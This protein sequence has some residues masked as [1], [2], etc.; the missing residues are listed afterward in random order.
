MTEQTLIERLQLGRAAPGNS[1]YLMQEAAAKLLESYEAQA[2]QAV[3]L[4]SW[5]R[6][7][8]R[9]KSEIESERANTK[10]VGMGMVIHKILDNI[11]SALLEKDDA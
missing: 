7:I 4:H 2:N 3:T 8:E 1:H 6:K 5:H 10:R 9:V 11:E